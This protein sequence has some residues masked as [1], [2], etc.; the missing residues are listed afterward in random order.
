MAG[1]EGPEGMRR[2]VNSASKI[3]AIKSVFKEGEKLRGKEISE[4]LKKR[5]YKVNSRN[6]QMFIYYKLLYKYVR[7]EVVNG[8]NLYALL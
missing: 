2:F 5:G 3:N 1:Q 7:K 4:R 6:I 8:V